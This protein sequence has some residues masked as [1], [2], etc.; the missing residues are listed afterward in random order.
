MTYSESRMPGWQRALSDR[1]AVDIVIA[2]AVA[3]TTFLAVVIDAPQAIRVLFGGSALVVLPGYVLVAML[4]PHRGSVA[5]PGRLSSIGAPDRVNWRVR[6]ALSFGLSLA[7][8]PLLGIVVSVSPWG[9]SDQTVAA[10][11]LAFVVIGGLLAA[12]VRRRLPPEDRFRIPL[13]RWVGEVQAALWSGPPTKRALN[14]LVLLSIGVA[15]VA[16]GGVI[17]MPQGGQSFTDFAV[18]SENDDDELVA[19]GYPEELDADD[20]APLVTAVENHEGDPTEYTVV[21]TMERRPAAGSDAGGDAT[22]SGETVELHRYSATVAPGQRWTQRHEL[23]PA[24]DGDRLRVHYYLYRGDAPTEPDAS[25]AY[26]HLWVTL[27]DE[28]A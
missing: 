16:A 26:R 28:A 23:R 3:A 14:A 1:V 20:P 13:D 21:V 22:A 27:G 24:L 17:A 11:F 12:I 19:G 8:L 10:A 15:L 18:L 6:L 2:W 25:T 9:F 5:A 7:L 4:F